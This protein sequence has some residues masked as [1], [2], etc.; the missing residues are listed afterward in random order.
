MYIDC[1]IK[2]EIKYY[3]DKTLNETRNL[4]VSV[5]HFCV[6]VLS[7]HPVNI[8]SMKINYQSR[9]ES[10]YFS[11]GVPKYFVRCMKFFHDNVTVEELIA[12]E[13]QHNSLVTKNPRSEP[14]ISP[15][16]KLSLIDMGY[17]MNNDSIYVVLKYKEKA[18]KNIQSLEIK[19]FFLQ[20]W[21]NFSDFSGDNQNV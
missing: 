20:L 8:K 6:I 14:D 17:I 15:E 11:Y 1:R 10:M 2:T 13:N 9:I 19:R 3:P 12:Y 4:E 16:I 7:I 5:N 21:V 18:S